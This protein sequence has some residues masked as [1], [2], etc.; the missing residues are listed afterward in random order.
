[1]FAQPR[2][3]SSTRPFSHGMR[4]WQRNPTY[5]RALLF[6]SQHPV[7]A[8]ILFLASLAVLSTAIRSIFLPAFTQRQL[9]YAGGNIKLPVPEWKWLYDWEDALP[10]HNLSLPFPEGK[11]G[12]ESSCIYMLVIP[13]LLVCIGYVKFS[14]QYK[15]QGVNNILNDVVM[16][17]H[18]AHESGMSYVFQG[19]CI[20]HI[21]PLPHPLTTHDRLCQ[22]TLAF[23][24]RTS[25]SR[26]NRTSTPPHTPQR[27]PRRPHSRWTMARGRLCPPFHLRTLVRRRLPCPRTSR[28][29]I[30]GNKTTRRISRRYHHLP[31]LAEIPQRVTRTLYRDCTQGRGRHG[32]D[33]RSLVVGKLEGLAD[34]GWAGG[35][36]SICDVDVDAGERDRSCSARE[37]FTSVPN[38]VY[39]FYRRALTGKPL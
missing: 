26:G 18:L 13:R 36:C 37:E 14:N 6:I 22:F 19:K 15:S 9:L 16:C 34:V 27:P 12:R 25:L 33:V 11:T 17:T 28:R 8:Y 5:R 38:E 24:S 4:K 20:P 21:S 32:A 7:V 39:T 35:L 29:R 3:P 31:T 1:M 10:Q 2:R 30:M 23:L